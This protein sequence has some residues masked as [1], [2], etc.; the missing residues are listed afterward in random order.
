M[1]IKIRDYYYAHFTDEETEAERS[2]ITDPKL[3]SQGMVGVQGR[4]PDS[5]ACGP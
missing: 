3:V 4:L 5:I 1:T 2:Y